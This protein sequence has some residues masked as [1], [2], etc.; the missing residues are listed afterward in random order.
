MKKLLNILGAIGLTTIA[1]ILVVACGTSANGGLSGNGGGTNKPSIL[2]I[3]MSTP[4]AK[5]KLEPPKEEIDEYMK[6][7]AISLQEKNEALSQMLDVEPDKNSE[8]Y[9]FWKYLYISIEMMTNWY[10][11]INQYF[12]YLSVFVYAKNIQT[13]EDIKLITDPNELKELSL[14]INTLSQY[15]DS[16]IESINLAIRELPNPSE[17]DRNGFNNIKKSIEEFYSTPVTKYQSILNELIEE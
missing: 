12:Q 15:N 2:L 10:K 4:L 3:D 17:N 13:E 9:Y 14:I 16:T 1:P 11:T 5:M 6:I 7:Y 8:G